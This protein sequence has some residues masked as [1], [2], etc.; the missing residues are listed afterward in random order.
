MENE[1][2]D[3]LLTALYVKLDD[4][5]EGTRRMGRPPLLT[6]SGL[7]CLAVALPGYE[8]GAR[9]LRFARKHLSG[10]FPVPAATV[11]LQQRLR[12][13]SPLVKKAFRVLATDTDLWF[14]N[15]AIALPTPDS[16]GPA[17]VPG[18]GQSLRTAASLSGQA[19]SPSFV[20][21][22]LAI[23]YER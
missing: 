5:I 13:A 12:T 21:Q 6:G 17:P 19:A 10:M 9:W 7:V 4:E 3:T 1:N 8:S 18:A 22:N 23:R 15:P 2:L 11:R 14:D 20:C 16:S